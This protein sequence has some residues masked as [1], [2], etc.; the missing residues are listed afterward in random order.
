MSRTT[1]YGFGAFVGSITGL[2]R[3]AWWD[4]DPLKVYSFSQQVLVPVDLSRNV[5]AARAGTIPWVDVECDDH[6]QDGGLTTIGPLF[7]TGS[8]IG[9]CWLTESYYQMIANKPPRQPPTAPNDA[10]DYELT[11]HVYWGGEHGDRRFEGFHAEELA[12]NGPLTQLAIW[13]GGTGKTGQPPAGVWWLDLSQVALPP[14]AGTTVAP[15]TP[16]ALFLDNATKQQLGLRDPKRPPGFG[17]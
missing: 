3:C 11:A 15:G 17:E 5:S 8:V 12:T 13:H 2:T 10:Y 6:R 14:G 4:D 9:A 7:P 16:G 1:L